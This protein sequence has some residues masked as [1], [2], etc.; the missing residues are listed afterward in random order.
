MA[1][2]N[3]NRIRRWLKLQ[4]V[5]VVRLQ[6]SPEK[7][8]AGLALGVAL[9]ILPSFGLGIIIA[10]FTA[11]IFRVNK[12]SAVIG[13]LIMNPWTA[14]FFWALSYL[15]G[16]LILGQDL[17]E[18][19]ELIKTLK[20][21]TDLWK[22]LVGSRLLLPYIIGNMLVTVAAS[23]MFYVGGLYTVR[24]YRKLK[25]HRLERKAVKLRGRDTSL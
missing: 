12:A 3:G 4:Y 21:H 10:L 8:A 1:L 6:D 25:K 15:A 19:I 9:G 13:T 23:A 2:R 16:S 11:G 7:I 20:G 18:T 17:R 14:T 22:S 24:E 5:R